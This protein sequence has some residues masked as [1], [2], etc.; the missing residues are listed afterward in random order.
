ML[1]DP[2]TGYLTRGLTQHRYS[3][4]KFSN[5]PKL[6]YIHFNNNLSEDNVFDPYENWLLVVNRREGGMSRN[7]ELS[8]HWRKDQ[9]KLL[10][11]YSD[12]LLPYIH[13]NSEQFKLLWQNNDIGVYQIVQRTM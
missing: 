4:G 10:R 2:I 1:T 6:G 8:G 12:K 11:Y 13:R 9:L 7:G 5:D 3:G